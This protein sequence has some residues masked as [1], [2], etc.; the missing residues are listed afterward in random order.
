MNQIALI[1]MAG[2]ANILFMVFHLLFPLMPGWSENLTTMTNEYRGIFLSFHY[3]LISFFGFMGVISTF[4]TK[5]LVFSP[6]R[7]YVLWMFSSLFIIRI[8]TEFICWG[9]NFPSSVIILLLCALPLAGFITVA[10]SPLKK[11]SYD[12]I[13]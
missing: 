3:I 4:Q 9:F 8:F 10:V 5:K 11:L 7:N 13:A 2:I 6:I 1:R 12:K